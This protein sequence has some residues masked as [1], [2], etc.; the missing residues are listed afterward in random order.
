[1]AFSSPLD[2]PSAIYYKA[3]RSG[4]AVPKEKADEKRTEREWKEKRAAFYG[5][6]VL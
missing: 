4:A 5:A 6:S 2:V 3:T 1:L